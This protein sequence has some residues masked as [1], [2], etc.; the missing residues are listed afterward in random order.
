M[1]GFFVNM[2]VLRTDLS[3][4]PG[5]GELLDR[6]RQVALGAYAHQNLPFE[7]LVEELRPNRDLRHTPLFQVSFQLLNVP[8]SALDLPGLS[9]RPFDSTDR[10]FMARSAKFDLDLALTDDAEHLHG[11]L[12]FD[13]DL[14]DGATMERLLAH[15]E[16]LLTGAL[17]NPGRRLSELPLL[18]PGEHSQA[19]VEWSDTR[20]A[21]PSEIRLHEL[22][23]A[24][25]RCSPDAVALTFEGKK[26]RYDELNACANR[27]AHALR[28]WGVG[29]GVRVGL[30]LERS[31]EMV[32]GLLGVL[33]A[34][35]AYVPLDPAYPRGRLAFMLTDAR[36]PLLLAQERLLATIQPEAE[37]SA[38]EPAPRIFYLDT[39]WGEIDGES[40]DN[41]PPW[42]LSTS[43]RT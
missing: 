43:W 38:D 17:E 14:F 25:A 7:K 35:G 5:F 8:V 36:V 12:D 34:G 11:L 32:V 22:F 20:A 1:I 6:V 30:C 18:T 19:V 13:A 21:L 23:E 37:G 16:R 9:P 2:L 42:D 40:A 3:G 24:Q 39:Q 26:L 29:P 33:K 27:L 41:L 10:S 28:R 15:L 4:D 31:L